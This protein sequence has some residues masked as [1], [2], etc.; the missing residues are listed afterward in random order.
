MM[1]FIVV[2]SVY[3]PTNSVKRVLFSSYAFQHLVFVDF[4]M[5]AILNSVKWYL[6]VD[7]ICIS[8]N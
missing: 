8:N 3:T 2:A 1:F 4:L 5:M 7:F 6:T